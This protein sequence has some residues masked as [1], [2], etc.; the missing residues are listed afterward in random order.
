MVV[1]SLLQQLILDLPTEDL[2]ERLVEVNTV[3]H[4]RLF[5]PATYI[6]Q[7]RPDLRV[8]PAARGTAGPARLLRPNLARASFHAVHVR[9]LAPQQQD[10]V[11]GNVTL[12]LGR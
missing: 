8:S 2:C 1:H 12:V 10:D 3:Y 7:R 11:L 6:G 4:Q 9:R 5:T